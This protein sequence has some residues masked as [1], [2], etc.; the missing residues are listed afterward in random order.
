MEIT[1]EALKEVF[2]FM[3]F[4]ELTKVQWMISWEVMCRMWWVYTVIFTVVIGLIIAE[5]L[6]W[7]R[8]KKDG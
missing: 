1:L 8:M 2:G 3:T 7:R 6:Q 5:V 4:K